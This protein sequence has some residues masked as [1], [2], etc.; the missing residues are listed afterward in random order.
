MVA[1]GGF[2]GQVAAVTAH[3]LVDDEHTGVRTVLADHVECEACALVCCRPCTQGL[4]DRNH[5]IIDGLGQTDDGQFVVVLMQVGSEICSG[6]VRV[7]AA[8]GVQDIDAILAQ[9]FSSESKRIDA[10]F[11][12]AALH[13]VL[14]V[15]QL[16]TRV[17]DRRAA[18]LT[19]NRC[20]TTSFFINDNV[21][22]GEQAMVAVLVEDDF[23]FGSD[24]GVALNEITNSGRKTRGKATSGQEGNT[25]NRHG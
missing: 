11:N 25:T 15:G 13:K 4:T 18:E 21:V 3:A 8:N 16:D 1:T 12:E 10:F 9:L 23:Y 5:V 22:A 17:T 6:R 19:Q 24:L 7:I 20:V 14:G 2:C